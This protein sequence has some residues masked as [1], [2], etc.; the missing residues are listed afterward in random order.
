MKCQY[1]NTE[2]KQGAKF[3]PNCGKEV[4]AFD[5]CKGCGQ[6]IK[7]GASFCPHCGANQNEVTTPIQEINKP[8]VPD[9]YVVETKKQDEIPVVEAHDEVEEVFLMDEEEG[10][11]KKWLWIVGVLLIGVIGGGFYFWNTNKGGSLSLAEVDADSVMVADTVVTDLKSVEVINT[12]LIDIFSK[13]F[14]MSDEDAINKFFSKEYREL[15]AKVEQHDNTHIDVGDIGFWNGNIW[16]GGQDGNPEEAKIVSVHHSDDD[17][18]A[19]AEVNFI[20]RE[21]EYHSENFLSV[22]LVFE[23]GNWYIDEINGYKQR[24]KEYVQPTNEGLDLVGKAY[25]GS[26][27]FYGIPSE[28]MISF[29]ANNKCRCVSD[30]AQNYST[31]KAIEGSYE[32]KNDKV[33]VHCND[34]NF[35]FNVTEQG[36]VLSFNESEGSVEE[37]GQMGQ[38]YMYLEYFGG[39]EKQ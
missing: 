13:A 5:V 12:R 34:N 38:Y 18:K 19:Y 23:D 20:H 10:N 22:D 6:Q 35:V 31:P 26:A 14:N 32:V 1:C 36:R 2:L 7:V 30:W 4:V 28:M 8:E 17:T 16:D 21:G 39:A 11:S 33:I 27:Y 9:T 25:K 37:V 24:M 29:Y 15:Y 3:C